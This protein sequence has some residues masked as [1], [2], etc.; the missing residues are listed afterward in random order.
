MAHAAC[1]CS[2]DEV[3]VRILRE[4]LRAKPFFW[5]ALDP[6]VSA[7]DIARRLDL[8][9][10]T[11][12]ARIRQWERDGF[13]RRREYVPHPGLFGFGLA[14]GAIRV[15]D[16][17][18][19]PRALDALSLVPGAFSA[20]DH[21]GE[22]I[23][24]CFV[25][26]SQAALDR[27]L[28]LVRALPGVSEV[29]PCPP[30]GIV[31]QREHRLTSLDWRVMGALRAHPEQSVKQ[32][33]RGLKVSPKTFTRHYTALCETK[34]LW[35]VPSV[36]FTKTQ[37]T[38]AR[39][40]LQMTEGADRAAALARFERFPHLMDV[41]D[42]KRILPHAESFDIY[43]L[44]PNAGAVEDL[45]ATARAITGVNAAD[46]LFPRSWTCYPAWADD[47]LASHLK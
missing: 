32:S 26:E 20:L 8:A 25:R 12:H 36:D 19:K 39:L 46:A 6:R 21:V 35:F 23:A 3:D 14:G 9:R 38:V 4:M 24:V 1:G 30:L 47:E 5:G 41:V 16:A 10:T 29:T 13:L 31:P 44:L 17:A 43:V 15:E 28:A 7:D 42:A 11:V 2:V 40:V 22:W 37:G 33:A 18:S 27:R 45:L 34:A